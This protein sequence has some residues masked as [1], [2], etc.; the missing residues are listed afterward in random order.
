MNV[1]TTILAP[2]RG[3]VP[4]LATFALASACSSASDGE[5]VASEAAEVTAS[6]DIADIARANVGKGACSD[7]SRGGR[8]FDTSC[9]GN[10]GEPEYWCADF[11]R[12][13]WAAAGVADTS[14]LSA[15]AGSFYLYGQRHGTIT[16]TPQVGDAVV[17]DYEG[18][19]YADHVALVVQVNS[20]HTI[21][22]IS[23]DWGGRNGTEAEFSS[24]LH[25]G[26]NAP[27]YASKTG[28]H[29]A[30]MGMT[31]SAIVRPAK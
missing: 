27:A 28:S 5:V 6:S 26:L 29:P 25:V 22:T 13:V 31:I 14:E 1:G 8:G 11:A 4:I 10:G 17:F 21:E 16:S 19:G 3:V 20:D 7:N 12:W 30:I 24:T 23:G 2:L 9:T 18:G 15:A